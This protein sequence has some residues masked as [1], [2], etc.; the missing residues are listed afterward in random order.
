MKNNFTFTK[1][2]ILSVIVLILLFLLANP[3]NV[4]MP[5]MIHMTVVVFFVVAFALFAIFIMRERPSDEREALN[6]SA[7]GRIAFLVGGSIL[8][9]GIVVQ[10]LENIFDPW[11]GIA[12]GGMVV[13]KLSAVIYEEIK[14]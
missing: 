2:I 10:T 8:I 12:L 5:N 1:E 3:F 6:R 13:A 9:L 14:H 11:L 4:W 7:A